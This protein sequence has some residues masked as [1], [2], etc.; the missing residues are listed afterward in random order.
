M[1]WFQRSKRFLKETRV[2]FSKVT[3]PT[4]DELRDSTGVVIFVSLLVAAFIG[5]VD[6]FFSRVVEFV[7]R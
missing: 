5:F 4:R 3:W 6:F 2:E 7:L 1:R